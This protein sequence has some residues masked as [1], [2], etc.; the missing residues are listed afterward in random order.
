MTLD[1]LPTA[2]DALDAI[3]A[4][5]EG[6]RPAVFLDYDG[7]LSP[8]VAT[9]DLAVLGDGVEAALVRLVAVADVAIVSG[10][11]L[12]DLRTRVGI[13]GLTYAGSHGF[14]VEYADG[15]RAVLGGGEAFEGALL[16][17]AGELGERLA[18]TPGVLVERKRFAL[19][20]HTRQT[21]AEHE[22]DVRTAVF[23]VAARHPTLRAS[24][25]KRV[26]ELRP[27][28]AWHKGAVVEA[29]LA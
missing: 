23:E 8:I 24:E 29:L 11:G 26:L 18:G 19:A 10:R 6:A 16:A 21:P 28:V 5:S 13:A 2:F 7:T 9:P 17:A 3:V 22:G 15:H 1:A 25:G 20:V 27:A 14:E 12:D 4:A